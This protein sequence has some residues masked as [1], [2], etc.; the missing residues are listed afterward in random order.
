V[1]TE[2]PAAV[3]LGLVNESTIDISISRTLAH[4]F[5]LGLLDPLEIQPFSFFSSGQESLSK[6]SSLQL[7][8]DATAQGIVLVKNDVNTLPLKKGIKL[9]VVGPLGTSQVGLMGDYYADAVCNDGTFS[10]VPTLSSAFTAANSGGTVTTV[11][12]CTVQGNDSSWGSAI[13]A[14]LEADAIV[15]ALGTDTSV[16][17][18]GTDL[19]D[20]GLPGVQREFGLAVLAA[21]GNKPLVLVIVSIFPTAFDD[22]LISPAI[23]LA[24]APTFGA[25]AIASSIFG[26][27]NRWGRAVMTVYPLKYQETVSIYDFGIVP[28]DVN[29]GRTYRYYTGSAGAPLVKFG[30]GL[31][32]STFSLSCSGSF[33]PSGADS[34]SISCNTTLLSGPDGDLVLMAF[35][36]PSSDI[37]GRIG[38]SHPVPLSSLA[39]FDRIS[40]GSAQGLVQV[41]IDLLASKALSL[42]DNTGASVLY[43][44]LHFIDI[45]GGSIN[46][47]T[48]AIEVPEELGR[49][50]K[51]PPLMTK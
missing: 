46:N 22:L 17:H 8:Q 32:Y 11:L 40:V 48:L 41:T 28:S 7:I 37:I 26:D 35:H 23:V 33:D 44:G 15:L 42:V 4:R 45:W 29:S 38:S 19:Q 5:R 47:V 13:A 27:E 49:V 20:I 14:V 1:P 21:A 31:S 2:L 51:R 36:R 39:G 16:G 25:P 9:A 6:P 34:I 43:P 24:Y 10:C 30:E 3:S 50:V 18:E 12:G